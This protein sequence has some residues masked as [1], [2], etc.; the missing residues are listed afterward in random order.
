MN[1]L[2]LIILTAF[3]LFGCVNK[4]IVAS[5]ATKF[6]L[7]EKELKELQ[8][9]SLKGN[10]NS[11]IK[12]ANF[13]AN[14]KNDHTEAV[15]WYKLSA[16][17]GNKDSALSLAHYYSEV[18]NEPKKAIYWYKAVGDYRSDYVH[19]KLG[20]IHLNDKSYGEARSHFCFAY[21]RE[22]QHEDYGALY[23]LKEVFDAQNDFI[24]ALSARILIKIKLTKG[25]YADRENDEKIAELKAKLTEN[26]IS[27]AEDIANKNKLCM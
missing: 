7:S 5:T 3:I 8:N 1:N 16:E 20:K 10:K 19:Y 4:P 21:L 6:W 22:L 26:D 18:F 9:K 23:Y 14:V 24:S 13:Y 11:G 27:T 12:I 2:I 17:Q 25:S 15:F